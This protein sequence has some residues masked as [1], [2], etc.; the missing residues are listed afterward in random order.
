MEE[1]SYFGEIGCIMG[2]IRRA[3]IK[4]LTTC[5]LQALSRRNLN[6]LLVEYPD[7]AEELKAVAKSRVQVRKAKARFESDLASGDKAP[8]ANSLVNEERGQGIEPPPTYGGRTFPEKNSDVP[9]EN[10]GGN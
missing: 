5:E 1:G 3:G 7:V 4:A 10:G 6:I 2:G 8:V 9:R